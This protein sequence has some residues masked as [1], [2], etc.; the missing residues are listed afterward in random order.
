MFTST[1]PYRRVLSS[2]L[3]LKSVAHQEDAERLIAFNGLT[4]GADVG[5]MTRS[6]ML[7]HPASRP[8]YWIYIEDEAT[9]TIVS[10]L[11]LLPWEWRY[12]G[13]TL[14]A[15][16]MGIVST[17]ETYRNK[18]LVREL[19][20]RFKELLRVDGFDISHIQ[21]I[22][23]F[24]RQFGYEYA[25]PLEPNWQIELRNLPDATDEQPYGIRQAVADD[26]PALVRLYD[27]AALTL[28]ISALRNSDEWHYL[29]DQCAIGSALDSEFWVIANA[30]GQIAGYWRLSEHG[31]GVGLRVME[32][33]RFSVSTA[34]S[35]LAWL[36]TA[37]VT[38]EKPTVQFKLPDNHDL[39]RVAR[40]KG[41]Y[42]PSAYA[43][44]IHLVDV[45]QL[46]R[47]ITPVLERRIAASPFAGYSQTVTI[48]LYREAFTLTF[49]G[50]KL[51]SVEAIGFSEAGSIR[52]PPLLFAPLMLGYRSRAELEAMYPDVS[53]WGE[54]KDLVD[55]LFPKLDA[56]LFSNY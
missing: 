35:L 27:E 22:P 13:V 17:L 38:R 54:S 45:G 32:A 49:D 25:I 11:A 44:Q 10:S 52:L 19:I 6:L 21:G 51:L 30:D 34:E 26:I 55:V 7:H 31:F 2:G 43:W 28:D 29:L 15:G 48:N 14:K 24:Y 23:Y 8:D 37:A 1:T 47:K 5:A 18:G 50:G 16:E 3:V 39:L 53:I 36:K 56:Y 9:S 20:A 40:W 46:L 41:A 12:E 33:S 42:D 4:F